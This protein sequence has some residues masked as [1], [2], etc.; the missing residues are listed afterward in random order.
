MKK[1][2]QMSNISDAEKE[3]ISNN[4]S[5]YMSLKN[6][7]R[8]DVCNELKIKYGTFSGW[9]NKRT[10]PRVEKI[11][12]MADYFEIEKSDLTEFKE[13]QIAGDDH[14]SQRENKKNKNG[15]F[16]QD[17]PLHYMITIPN[18]IP[19]I[20]INIYDPLPADVPIDNLD[21]A[22][23][24]LARDV[25]PKIWVVKNKKNYIGIRIN[26][27][28]M[29]PKFAVGE[30]VIVQMQKD[31]IDDQYV[32]AWVNG[33]DAIVRQIKKSNNEITLIPFN[34]E[35][36]S[37]TYNIDHDEIVIL[38]IVVQKRDNVELLWE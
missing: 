21:S 30:I 36:P 33:K 26:N 29:Y 35:Y 11:K 32:V 28:S 17:D 2:Y 20:L 16:E 15:K 13:S 31:F 23:E 38:G 4:I 3:I 14:T 24:V 10:Y 25:I 22:L 12:M 7:S 19:S 34:R 27:D 5:Y 9:I 37:I 6:V 18:E 8:I 1:E